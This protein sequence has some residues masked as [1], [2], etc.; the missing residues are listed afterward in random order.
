MIEQKIYLIAFNVSNKRKHSFFDYFLKLI[1]F[2][3]TYL[4]LP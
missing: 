3:V 1:Y 4:W 2:A